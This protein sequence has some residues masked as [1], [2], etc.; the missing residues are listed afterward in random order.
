[1]GV[2]DCW[3]RYFRFRGIVPTPPFLDASKPYMFVVSPCS[4]SCT[5]AAPLVTHLETS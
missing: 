5:W 3:R 1:M 4:L 2:W